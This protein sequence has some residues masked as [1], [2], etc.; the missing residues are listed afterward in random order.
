[1]Y[2]S[3][4]TR[5]SWVKSGPKRLV[6]CPVGFGIGRGLSEEAVPFG[7]GEDFIEVIEVRHARLVEFFQDVGPPLKFVVDQLTVVGGD[8]LLGR[9][10]VFEQI[11]VLVPDKL[12]HI[13]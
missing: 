1:M 3:W 13:F 8:A 4:V 10:P 7:F 9:H 6:S 11:A 2:E 5:S 12:E